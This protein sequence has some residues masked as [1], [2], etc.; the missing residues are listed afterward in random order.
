MGAFISWLL[1]G[2]ATAALNIGSD[3]VNKV[4]API[5]QAK[6]DTHRIDTE[7]ATQVAAYAECGRHVQSC[8]ARSS[9]C[10]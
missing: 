10:A 2:G 1:S 3:V 4:V 8:C 9:D 6:T 5:A 7:A